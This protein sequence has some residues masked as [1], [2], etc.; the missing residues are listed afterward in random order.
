MPAALSYLER[1]VSPFVL[2]WHN[3][4][5]LKIFFYE[6]LDFCLL[7]H[8][9]FVPLG[10]MCMIVYFVWLCLLHINFKWAAS[11]KLPPVAFQDKY[12]HIKPWNRNKLQRYRSG[13][14]VYTRSADGFSLHRS[15][16]VSQCGANLKW[17]KSLEKQSILA[18]EVCVP[19]HITIM[20]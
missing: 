6:T 11:V 15:G 9:V 5:I 1:N 3:L 12:L 16:V 20:P 10:G 18:N 14:P 7:P 19:H 13:Q 2:I 17:T 8:L 4:S